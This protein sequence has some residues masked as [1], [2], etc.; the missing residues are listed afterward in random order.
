MD[1]R[2]ASALGR[3][4]ATALFVGL[5]SLHLTAAQAAATISQGFY[6]ESSLKN[7]ANAS[8]CTITFSAIPAGKTVIVQNVG[9]IMQINTTNPLLS[10]T[11][12]SKLGNVSTQRTNYLLPTLMGTVGGTRNFNSN[13]TVL[14][15]MNAG[16]IPQIQISLSGAAS[17]FI[18]N[19]SISGQIKP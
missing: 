19:C 15:I 2:I 5:A 6:Q 12:S 13:N 1:I 9:C 11:L 10:L 16:E 8:F 7:C 4:V 17:V 14:D 3:L 18:G